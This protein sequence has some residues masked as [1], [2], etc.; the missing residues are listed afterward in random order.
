MTSDA[1][2]NVIDLNGKVAVI[3]GAS[4]GIGRKCALA[5]AGHGCN[6]VIAA[7]SVIA[8]PGLP[9]TIFTVAAE[10]RA[11]GVEVL[12]LEMDL[13]KLDQI[14]KGVE[15]IVEKFDRIDI[16]VNNASALWWHTIEETPMKKFDLI[17]AI[18]TRGAFA[19]TKFCLPYIVKNGWGRVISMSPP[20]TFRTNLSGKTAYSISKM[21]MSLVALGIA[22]EYKNVVTGNCLWPA[23]VIES[24]ASKNFKLGKREFWRK[25][26]ILSDC[27]LGII[28]EDNSF[29]GNCLIDD[30][31]LR[32]KGYED[33]DFVQY[34][35]NPSLEPPRILATSEKNVFIRRGDVRKLEKDQKKSKI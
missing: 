31:Y 7:K 33:S 8:K 22:S 23:T 17:M 26:D 25:A 35:C 34:R 19:L 15:K 16:V 29:T 3:S 30:E 1:R 27:V 12:A 21:G 18:N 10:V 6:I 2:L 13:R 32:S 5:L 14:E 11:L 20:V 28:S 9:G 24:Y 4:R